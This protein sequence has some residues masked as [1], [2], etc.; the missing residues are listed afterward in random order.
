MLSRDRVVKISE[1]LLQALEND[2]RPAAITEDESITRVEF[3]SRAWLLLLYF[4]AIFL[5]SFCAGVTTAISKHESLTAVATRLWPE[6][7]LIGLLLAIATLVYFTKQ[8]LRISDTEVIVDRGFSPFR[9]PKKI[10]VAAIRSVRTG[11]FYADVI[12]LAG[13]DRYV[14]LETDEGTYRVACGLSEE[15]CAAVA[16]EIRQRTKRLP[17]SA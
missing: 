5:V 12:G 9:R 6:A 14:G 17:A 16:E 3:R 11:F 4:A 10:P 7:L 2:A 13:E 15:Q 8:G 1:D